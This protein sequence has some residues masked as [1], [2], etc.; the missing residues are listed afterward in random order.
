[1]REIKFRVRD[2]ET[3][4]VVGYE[5]IGQDY[6]WGYAGIG[7]ECGPYQRPP[8]CGIRE[9]YTGI[10]DS[11][12]KG[13]YEGDVVKDHNGY[14]YA[15]RFGNVTHEDRFHH[16]GHSR[17]GWYMEMLAPLASSVDVVEDFGDDAG[18]FVTILGSIHDDEYKELAK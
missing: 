16:E 8:F 5:W 18:E 14:V 15:V 3:K 11:D 7:D 4:T 6:N 10:K 17:Y 1:M 13:I 9:Q 2:P 12:G